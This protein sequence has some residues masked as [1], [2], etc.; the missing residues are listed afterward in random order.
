MA[1]ETIAEDQEKKELTYDERQ[2][3]NRACA[4]SLIAPVKARDVE[5]FIKALAAFSP[6]DFI[7]ATIALG[8]A[9]LIA[10]AMKFPEPIKLIFA[11]LSEK[12][13]NQV[14]DTAMARCARIEARHEQQRKTALET[15]LSLATPGQIHFTLQQSFGRAC[16]GD[17]WGTNSPAHKETR[18][19][20]MQHVNREVNPPAPVQSVPAS[21]AAD[22]NAAVP[23]PQN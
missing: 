22:A 20:L 6:T 1:P 23:E 21:P 13:A 2:A 10:G 9:L 5:G 11:S 15:L 12:D 14:F 7:S 19:A 3:I 17:M 4:A 8:E 18:F 16:R